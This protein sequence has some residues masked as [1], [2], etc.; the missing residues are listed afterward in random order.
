MAGPTILPTLVPVDGLGR[1]ESRDLG[2][3]VRL[4]ARTGGHDHRLSRCPT[5]GGRDPAFPPTTYSALQPLQEVCVDRLRLRR[6]HAVGEARRRSSGSRSPRAWCREGAGVGKG[7]DLVVVA[8]HDSVGT[9]IAFRSSV[10]SVSRERLD[11]VVVR[12]GAAHHALTPP[13][14]DDAFGALRAGPVEAVE[15]PGGDIEVELRTVRPAAPR[16][17]P[18]NTSIGS[19]ARDCSRLHHDRRHGA[20]QHRLGDAALRLGRARRSGRPRR[21]RSNGRHGWRLAGRDA[22]ASCRQRRRHRCPCRCRSPSGSSGHGR[23][24]RAR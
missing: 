10:K 12:L 5:A 13:V 22:S 24:G 16:G 6:R 23:A 7:D 14:A 9:L 21:R 17:S 4:Q 11:A 18:S 3:S 15:R 1:I 20:D 8:V 19:A 2:L